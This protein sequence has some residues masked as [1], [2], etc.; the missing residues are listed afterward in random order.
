[1]TAFNMCTFFNNC[2]C[3]LNNMFTPFN[4]FSFNNVFSFPSVFNQFNGFTP[5]FFNFAQQTP[6]FQM[7]AMN[8]TQPSF[9]WNNFNTGSLWNQTPMNF[10]NNFSFGDTFS[11]TTTSSVTRLTGP[12]QSQLA[13]K[14]LSYVGKVNSDAEGNR[15]FS[16]GQNR[17]WCSDFVSTTVHNVYGSK[18]PSDFPSSL[19]SVASIRS[20]GEKNNRF[21]KL[22]SSNKSEFIA[23]NVKVGDI[24]IIT[25]PAG[26]HNHTAIVTKVNSDGSFETVGGN[27][28]NSV[29]KKT[30]TYKTENLAGFVS[31]DG[32]A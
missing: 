31:M 19:C 27:E 10:N 24:M 1:M 9:N 15:L 18:L 23:K 21:L 26:K 22:P 32:I 8:F 14:A 30:R 20:W 6:L 28:S 29:K 13:Q 12:L 16:K 2:C 17:P 25:R 4:S 5:S 3:G 7:P 11:R